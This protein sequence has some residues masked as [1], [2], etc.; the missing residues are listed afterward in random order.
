MTVVERDTLPD[1]VQDRAGVPQ[2]RHVHALLERGRR[3]LDRLFPGFVRIMLERG[4]LD[5]D[6]GLDF[7]ALRLIGWQPRGRSPYP[8]LFAS[9]TL[10]ESVVRERLRCIPNVEFLERTSVA[11]LLAE[12]NGH[13]RVRGVRL[14]A[15]DG[16]GTGELEAELVVD[17]SGRGS[18]APDWLRALGLTPPEETVVD[19]SAAYAT[20]WYRA[21]EPSS[22]P[23]SWWWKGIWIDP[24][25]PDYQM[26]GVLIPVE[27]GRW[28]VT[29][30]GV[31]GHYP[32]ADEDGFA[33]ALGKLRS[34]ILAQAVALAKPIS[35]VYSNREMENRFRHY[36][37]WS[38][39]LPG[40][41]A[42]GDAACKF[43]PVYGQGMTTAAVCA[44]ILGETLAELGPTSAELPP[45]LF[46]RQGAFL[47]E[48]WGLAVGADFR[49]EGTTGTPPL[50]IGVFNVYLDELFRTTYD[51]MEVR[52]ATI[53]VMHMLRPASGLFA[54]WM[55]ARVGTHA[56]RRLL[57]WM[58]EAAPTPQ[59]SQA[60]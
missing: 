49:F 2:A 14:Q 39:R 48:P 26:A 55:L 41:V 21:P 16:G 37:R 38:E 44:T 46:R 17:A 28:I 58:P 43:N 33:A 20:R 15:R 29:L 53:D 57:A 40:F 51:D 52:D 36:E 50:G 6:F 42:V 9:R 59:P 27:G 18:K 13:P 54:P 31:S 32:P 56:L 30:A 25:P 47:Q 1:G 8:A 19:S 5:L 12:G 22:W 35:P 34:P 7:A 23:A 60:T 10:I 11:G 24:F 3:D 45:E 4:A